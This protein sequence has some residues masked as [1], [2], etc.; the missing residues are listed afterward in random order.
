MEYLANGKNL[1]ADDEGYLLEADYSDSVCEAIVAAEGVSL[2]EGITG[3][4]LTTCASSIASMATRQTSAA[5]SRM[6]ANAFRTATASDCTTCFHLDR[7]SKARA[8]RVYQN[9]S[10]RGDIDGRWE[11]ARAFSWADARPNDRRARPRK[12]RLRRGTSG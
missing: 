7:P 1:A 12:R 10:E 6:S 11:T 9:P 5:C 4:S 3:R 8:S 2:S